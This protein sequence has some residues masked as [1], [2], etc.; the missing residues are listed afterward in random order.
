MGEAK[1]IIGDWGVDKSHGG[2]QK[3]H[4]GMLS[5]GV[6]LRGVLSGCYGSTLSAVA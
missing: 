3:I 5:W 2:E 1:N 6:L 4:G